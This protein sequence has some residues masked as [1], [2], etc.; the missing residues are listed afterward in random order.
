MCVFFLF[1]FLPPPEKKHTGKWWVLFM[2]SPPTQRKEELVGPPFGFPFFPSQPIGAPSNNADW[3]SF[4]FPFAWLVLSRECGN[5]PVFGIPLKETTSWMV[6]LV[7]PCLIP[8]AQNH[9]F[10]PK[11]G[12]SMTG[13]LQKRTPIDS[14]S[15]TSSPKTAPRLSF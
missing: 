13:V 5:E 14:P 6:F 2:P 8:E 10:P 7:I 3:V 4:N 12:T 1:L 11:T 15:D 9:G